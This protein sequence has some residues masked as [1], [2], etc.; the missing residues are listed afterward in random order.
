MAILR[1]DPRLEGTDDRRFSGKLPA[2]LRASG[3]ND[4]LARYQLVIPGSLSV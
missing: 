3:K 4:G 2:S 1:E